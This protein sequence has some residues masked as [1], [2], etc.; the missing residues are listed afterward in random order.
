MTTNTHICST[1]KAERGFSL[2]ELLVAVALFSIVAVVA[3]GSLMSLID[4][5][6]KAR[7]QQV[8]MGNLSVPMEIMAEE[9]REL[10]QGTDFAITGG[11]SSVTFTKED[12]TEAG[13]RLSGTSIER[14]IDGAWS[15][16][17]GADVDIVGLTFER[18][19]YNGGTDDFPIVTISVEAKSG[20]RIKTESTFMLQTTVSPQ[21]KAPVF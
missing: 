9:M 5:N 18:V 2:V 1:K 4:A 8:V 17:T 10:K 7:T 3:A 14:N 19:D 16:L 13:F 12:D 15:N 21:Y 6:S 11:G 20:S